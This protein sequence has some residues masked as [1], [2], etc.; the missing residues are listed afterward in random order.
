M[1]IYPYFAALQH[2]LASANAFVLLLAKKRSANAFVLLL[3]VRTFEKPKE[4]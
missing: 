3:G 2:V 4:N 1:P